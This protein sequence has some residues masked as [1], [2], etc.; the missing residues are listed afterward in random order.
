MKKLNSEE[1]SQ[2]IAAGCGFFRRMARR[3]KSVEWGKLYL[4]CKQG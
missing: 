4:S 3:T 1:M 2:T